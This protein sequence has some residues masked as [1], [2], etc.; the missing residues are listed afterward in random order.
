MLL[1]PL[2]SQVIFD[3]NEE[4]NSI[5]GTIGSS[6]NGFRVIKS[7]SIGTNKKTYGP[8]GNTRGEHFT[9]SFDDGSFAGLYGLAGGYLDSIGV[10]LKTI[11]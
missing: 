3:Y 2:S 11:V 10:Y 7:I 9:V 1:F 4:I 5:S 6:R 8:Y